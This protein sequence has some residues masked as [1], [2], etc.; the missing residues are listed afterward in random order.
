MREKF[1]REACEMCEIFL[2]VM[3]HINR[4]FAH[5]VDGT[6]TPPHGWAHPAGMDRWRS[7]LTAW[8]HAIN[9]RVFSDIGI[10]I[11]P[12]FGL[13]CLF[14]DGTFKHV[15]RP[16]QSQQNAGFFSNLQQSLYT[17]YKSGHGLIFQAVTSPSGMI[18]DFY[19]PGPGRQND[20]WLVRESDLDARLLSLFGGI[21]YTCYGDSI[22]TIT[23]AIVRRIRGAVLLPWQ[24][25]INQSLNRE[26]TSVEHVFAGVVQQF[27]FLNFRHNHKL[28]DSACGA[29]IPFRCGALLFNLQT[30]MNG[31]NQVTVRFGLSPPEVRDYMAGGVEPQNIEIV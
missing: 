21:G 16:G 5:L 14:V 19:G 4:E 13:I 30:C 26:R 31:G 8:N 28:F 11:P 17:R 25:Q 22:Y 2:W 7:Q 10:N 15:C 24:S 29:G 1:N 12:M 23:Q 6:L 9:S 20:R 3:L 18:V 27:K